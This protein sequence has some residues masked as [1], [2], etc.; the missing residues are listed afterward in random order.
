V[1][2]YPNNINEEWACNGD[3]DTVLIRLTGRTQLI[4]KVWLFDRPNKLD[5]ITAYACFSDGKTMIVCECLTMQR[6]G[7][8]SLN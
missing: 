4:N 3:F 7:L 5:Q 6:K 1:G 2:G 8:V